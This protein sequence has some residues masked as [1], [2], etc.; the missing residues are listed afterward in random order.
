M[1][2]VPPSSPIAQSGPKFDH[3]FC[4]P[5]SPGYRW[6]SEGNLPTTLERPG[7]DSIDNAPFLR[8]YF[9]DLLES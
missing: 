1:F 8:L 3:Y 7:A 9:F 2:G 6:R 4:E 5:Q